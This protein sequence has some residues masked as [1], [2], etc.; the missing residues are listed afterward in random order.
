MNA[1]AATA[2]AS[3]ASIVFSLL[4]LRT[5]LRCST[6]TFDWMPHLR[7]SSPNFYLFSIIDYRVGWRLSLV[8]HQATKKVE[9]MDGRVFRDTITL[10]G[11]QE[12][13]VRRENLAWTRKDGGKRRRLEKWTRSVLPSGVAV[14][15][16]APPP[17]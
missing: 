17:P 7:C 2:A 13:G 10:M 3:I 4:V 8:I 14:A 11:E 16:A 15:N 12:N 9:L 5:L 6:A 1:A